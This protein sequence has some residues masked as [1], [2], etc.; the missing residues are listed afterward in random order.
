[1]R[2]LLIANRSDGDPGYVGEHLRHHGVTF[3]RAERE[4]PGDWPDLD[5]VD[6][7]LSLG[8]DWSVY[9]E[10]VASSVAAEAAALRTA[11]ERGVPV[12]GI[13]FGGQMIAHALGGS[14]AAAPEPEVGWFAVESA[15]PAVAGDGP[16]F[17][18]HA[19]R[20]VPPPGALALASSPRAEQAFRI[21]RTLA[22]QFHPEVD[23]GIIR[24]W[25]SGGAAELARHGVD[26]DELLARTRSEVDRT[27]SSAGR[28]VDWFLAEVA[29][30][31]A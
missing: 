4:A 15:V 3:V 11:H 25:A 7:V 14:V 18:W 20:F 8:S 22:L 24:R 1:M 31:P 2:A 10:D 6:L 17:Q 26:G 27:R 23:D 9:W 30:T 28:L 5:G 16:W 12:L 29:T 19:D 13:C 21:G